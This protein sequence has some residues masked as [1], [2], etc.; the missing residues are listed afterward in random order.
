MGVPGFFAWL[1]KNHK[2]SKIITTSLPEDTIIKTL[3]LDTNCLIHPQCFKV[4]HYY[5]NTLSLEKLEKKMFKR[6]LNYIDYL[7]GYTNPQEVFISIDGVA[8]F[9]KMSQQRK[10]RYK[11]VIDTEIYGKVKKKYNKDIP[12]IWSNTSITPGTVFMEKLHQEILKYINKN[13]IGLKIKYTYSSYHSP[14]EGE[15]KILQDIKKRNNNQESYVIYGLDADLIFLALASQKNNIYLLREELFLNK[16]NSEEDIKETFDIITDV[17]EELNFVSMDETKNSIN[18]QMKEIINIDPN[19]KVDF[20]NLTYDFIVLCYFLGNDFL[21]NIPSIEIKN[22]GI[23]FL[24]DNYAQVYKTLN[25]HLT[26]NNNNKIEINNIFLGL[27]FENLSK[28]EDYYFKVKYPKWIER[29]NRRSCPSD[30]PYEK[31]IW[32]I[33]NMRS[34]FTKVYDDPINLGYNESY[35]WKFRFY[36]YY[37]GSVNYQK[38]LIQD[39]CKEYIN[40]IVWNMKYYFDEC[41][42]WSYYYKFFHCPFVSDLSNYFKNN[43]VNLLNIE[44]PDNYTVTPLIQ[45]LSVLPPSMNNLLP[46]KYASLMTNSKSE[47]IDFFPTSFILDVLYKESF[48]KCIPLLPNI[49]I[50][51]LIN[52]TSNIKLSDEEKERNKTQDNFIIKY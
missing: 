38:E 10:R 8:P 32:E 42:S 36:E 45:L 9:A 16:S 50:E 13:R 39:M 41:P 30:D 29:L 14:G 48:H 3:Y 51:R 12:T 15:H 25:T 21:P 6:I 44:I 46:P 5:D 33:D 1:L 35:L 26:Y 27:L 7:I 17:S 43:K 2:K 37:Y 4:L 18:I 24:L 20:T 23:D 34:S 47:I 11:T 28:Y 49:N 52:A 19:L 22:D 31:E 40:G